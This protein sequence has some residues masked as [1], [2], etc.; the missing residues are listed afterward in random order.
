MATVDSIRIKLTVAIF[1]I[2][3]EKFEHPALSGIGLGAATFLSEVDWARTAPSPLPRVVGLGAPAGSIIY[4]LEIS[5]GE[6][7]GHYTD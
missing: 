5:G 6:F 4:G 2:F 1:L 7:R 3:R